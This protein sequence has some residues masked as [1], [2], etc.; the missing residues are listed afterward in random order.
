MASKPYIETQHSNKNIELLIFKIQ[1]ILT[2]H[3]KISISKLSNLQTIA[4]L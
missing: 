1:F 2:H 3:I 4:N